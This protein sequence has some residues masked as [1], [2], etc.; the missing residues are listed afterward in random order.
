M[1]WRERIQAARARGRFTVADHAAWSRLDQCPAGEVVGA[2]GC[3]FEG[4]TSLAGPTVSVDW[5][6]RYRTVWFMGDEA[7]PAIVAN[8]FDAVE[9]LLEAIEDRTL[10]LKREATS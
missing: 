2:L 4:L 7:G 1:D 10:E 3:V 6:R 9:R 8:D 5:W